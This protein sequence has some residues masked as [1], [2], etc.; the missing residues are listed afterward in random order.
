MDLVILF[1]D[2]DDFCQ[3][4]EPAFRKELIESGTRIR[5]R[6]SKMS[7]SEI[8][9][10]VIAFHQSNFR[11]FKHFYLMLMQN[12]RAE[13]PQLLSYSRF[14]YLMKD[15]TV[16]LCVYLKSRFGKTRGIAFVDATSLAV[17]GNKR[18]NRHRVFAGVAARGKTTTGWFYGFKL[19][20]IIN[21]QGE[22][23]AVSVTPGNVDDRKPVPDLS[24]GIWGKLFGDKGY[25]SQGLFE[26]LL[27]KGLK[28]I[29]TLRKNMKPKL[30][31][32]W[33]KLMLR[34]RSLIETVNDQLKNISQIEHTRHRSVANW[35][36]NLISGL[37]SYTWQEKKPSLRFTN[38]E[39]HTLNHL[40]ITIP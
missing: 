34:K 12:H 18:I 37:I 8:M 1:C 36:V 5:Q 35:M 6:K 26:T 16:P 15:A 20:L 31:P 11:T 40:A 22:I 25:I 4:F 38:K 13:F 17:C 32:L 27:G 9:T 30:L 21:D 10:I 39:K 33:D 28:L 14:V 3:L 29:T 7:L 19:H 24:T 23:L 2:V